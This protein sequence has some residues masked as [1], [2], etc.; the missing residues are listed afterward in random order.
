MESTEWIFLEEIHKDFVL[1]LR[2]TC[3]QGPCFKGHTLSMPLQRENE[4]LIRNCLSNL[5][6]MNI[7]IFWRKAD[8]QERVTSIFSSSARHTS[9]K[10]YLMF[11]QGFQ[12]AIYLYLNS[13]VWLKLKVTVF[14]NTKMSTN[15]HSLSCFLTPACMKHN[16]MLSKTFSAEIWNESTNPYKIC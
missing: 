16:T 9:F 10:I 2:F 8:L 4:T 6:L 13:S 1:G 3:P 7:W 11:S 15:K 12:I 5:S 14:T